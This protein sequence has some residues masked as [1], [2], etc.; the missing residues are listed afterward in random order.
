MS[1]VQFYNVRFVISTHFIFH[2][3]EGKQCLVL[4]AEIILVC[5]CTTN[6]IKWKQH[7]G[8]GPFSK[9]NKVGGVITVFLTLKVIQPE[10]ADTT[11]NMSALIGFELLKDNN[12]KRS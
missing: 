2:Q 10:I 6:Q 11:G 9:N 8:I 3:I 12:I 1:L 5:Q 4:F 7:R